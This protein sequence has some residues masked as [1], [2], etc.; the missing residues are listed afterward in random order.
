[1][2]SEKVR[3][4]ILAPHVHWLCWVGGAALLGCIGYCTTLWVPMGPPTFIMPDIGL[5]CGVYCGT[6]IPIIGFFTILTG[7]VMLFSGVLL[8]LEHNKWGARLAL[9]TGIL[10]IPVGVLPLIA[11]YITW[12]QS[13]SQLMNRPG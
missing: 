7:V 5:I 13:N 8:K 11:A 12:Q 10:T 2:F 3:I 9:I 1:M 6:R 4:G